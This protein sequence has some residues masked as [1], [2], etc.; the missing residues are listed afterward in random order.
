[1]SWEHGSHSDPTAR[2]A[3]YLE[4]TNT[5]Q[6]VLDS[7]SEREAGVIT[8][9]FGIIDGQRKT[10]D[11]IA[12]I[13]GI[14]RERVRQIESEALAKLRHSS[15]SDLLAVTDGKARVGFI[16]AVFARR[17]QPNDDLVLC[18]HCHKRWFTPQSEIPTGGRIRKYCSDK[19]RQAAYRA[20]CRDAELPD[21]ASSSLL[22]TKDDKTTPYD[23]LGH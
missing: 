13:Y 7:L 17:D 4:G 19:C 1:M 14:T 23:L 22:T 15:R 8:L 10:L 12:R 3:L 21:K 5:L 11:E 6:S 20:R 16:D 18:L 2:F 9:R